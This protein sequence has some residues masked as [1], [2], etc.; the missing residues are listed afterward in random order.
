[1]NTNTLK[2]TL[3]K[4]TVQRDGKPIITCKKVLRLA[5]Q[6]NVTPRRVGNLCDRENIKIRQ[7]QL[8]CF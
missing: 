4:A 1:M 2:E 5:E 8:G 6:F 7:C 3:L